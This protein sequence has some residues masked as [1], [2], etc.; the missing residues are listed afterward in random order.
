MPILWLSFGSAFVGTRVGVLSVPPFLFAGSRFVI[1]GALLLLLCAWRSGFRLSLSPREIG[2]GAL[3][4]ALIILMGQGSASWASTRLG[5]GLVA[6][7]V[8]TMPLWS[9][10]L[11]RLFQGTR[12]GGLAV[13]GLVLGFAGVVLLASPTGAGVHLVPVLVL[14]GGS[15]AFAVGTLVASGSRLARRPLVM[16]ALQMLTG[17]TLQ[18]LLG[19][20]IG[21][22]AH[23]RMAAVLQPDVVEA[24]VFLLIGACLIGFSV[25]AWLIAAASP[26]VVS[27]Q[28]YA[29][30]VVA[31]L[32][33]WLLLG[34]SINGRILAAAGISLAG[35][36]LLVV[37]Q[38]RSRAAARAEEG[39][40][41]EA[42]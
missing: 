28:A 1:G 39:E 18:L 7:L 29:V 38:A 31:I 13:G 19:L 32:L 11:A 37:G 2:E 15:M 10:V 34:E 33:G 36:A 3:L 27:S 41:A 35:V 8:S 6:V 12:L 21:E 23:L 25:Y 16:A 26:I 14:T 4:G 9:A 5:P 30:P 20:G 42:A 22:P 24:F 40:L 17:G